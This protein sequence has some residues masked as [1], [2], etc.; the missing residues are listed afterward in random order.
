V[1]VGSAAISGGELTVADNYQYIGQCGNALRLNATVK[2]MIVLDTEYLN[3]SGDGTETTWG[4]GTLNGLTPP[5]CWTPFSSGPVSISFTGN[6]ANQT[7][8][9]GQSV[10]VDL[11]DNWSGTQTPFTYA[12]TSGSLAGTGLTLSSAGVLSGTATEAAVAGLVITGTDADLNTAAS[13]AFSVTVNAAPSGN[14]ATVS[15]TMP[16]M[17]VAASAENSSGVATFTSEPLKDLT[18]DG[19]NL[20]ANEALDY[21]AFYNA[22]TGALVLRVTGLSTNASGIFTVENA[23][24]TAGVTYKV[25]W[26]VTSQS[27]GRMPE[28]AAV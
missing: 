7:F 6:I 14:E 21:V 26:K 22:T 15:F 18:G 11:S 13:N 5:A 24:L 27:V 9:V 10:N 2:R 19:N 20:L 28:K 23:A 1:Q 25:D 4:D 17:I 12:L 16:Q 3:A 8:T